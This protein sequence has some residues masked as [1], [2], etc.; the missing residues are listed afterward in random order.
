M[1]YANLEF[2]RE[3]IFQCTDDEKPS[4]EVN[5]WINQGEAYRCTTK[6]ATND[7]IS[8]EASFLWEDMEGN[9]IIPNEKLGVRHIRLSR[10][11]PIADYPLN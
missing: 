6:D 7:L 8:G 1:S 9:L 10:F 3:F 2:K 11:A 4:F 5:M